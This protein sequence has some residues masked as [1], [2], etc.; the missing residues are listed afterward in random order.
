MVDMVDHF[1]EGGFVVVLGVEVAFHVTEIAAF[2]VFAEETELFFCWDNFSSCFC[3]LVISFIKVVFS[4]VMVVIRTLYSSAVV[5]RFWY[6][7]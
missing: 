7:E 4:F 3:K 5:F 2:V 1:I 6:N